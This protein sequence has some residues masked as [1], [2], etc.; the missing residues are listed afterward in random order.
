MLITRYSSE[1]PP[2]FTLVHPFV[3]SY[4]PDSAPVAVSPLRFLF[5]QSIKLHNKMGSPAKAPKVKGGAAKPK[6]EKK[7]KDPNAPKVRNASNT[8]C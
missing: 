4:K 2:Y 3:W 6:K 5:K 7:A 1:E 8:T